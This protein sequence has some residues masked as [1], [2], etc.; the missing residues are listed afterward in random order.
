MMIN[1]DSLKV[2]MELLGKE[3]MRLYGRAHR[4]LALVSPLSTGMHI[5]RTPATSDKLQT[6]DGAVRKRRF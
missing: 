2:P 4:S 1:G 3:S 6:G 5:P